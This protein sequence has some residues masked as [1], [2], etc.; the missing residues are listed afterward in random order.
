MKSGLYDRVVI[1]TG[2]SS[3]IGKACALEFARQGARIVLAARRSD[4]LE[5][6]E[7]EIR[8]NSGEAHTVVTDVREIEACKALIDATL[9]K[10]GRIDILVNNAGISM[11]ASFEELDLKVIKELMDTNFYG[12]VYCTKFALPHILKHKGT[13]VGIS[14]ISGLTPLPGRTGYA[15][16]KHAMDGFF[17]TL[18]LENMKKG[19]NVLVVH[20]GFTASNIRTM[21]LNRNGEAQEETPRDEAR[22]MSSERVAKIIASAIIKRERDLIL[23]PQ[24]KLVVWMHKNLPGI[25]D[26]I[27]LRE[28]S[29]EPGS[30]V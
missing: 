27:I 10:Y 20:P 8:E 18:R 2:A 4:E 9:D 25:A 19:L 5:K 29:R 22:M 26:R 30:P 15:A 28:M 1:I 13:I 14:S 16:S 3:G 21:A 7:A 12:A 23:T 6:V 24:G 11:R 17:N